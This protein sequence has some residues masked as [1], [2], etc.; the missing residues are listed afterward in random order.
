MDLDM[1]RR[2]QKKVNI[3]LVIGKADCLTKTEVQKLKKRILSDLED[4]HIHLYQFPDCDS[5]EDE[6]FKQQD[7]ELKAC[8]PFAVV[9]SNVILEVAGKK[10]RGRQYPWGVVDVEN[11]EHS[12]FIKL[13]TMLISTHM[14]D[15]K[16]TTQDVHYENFRAQCI[17]QISQHAL[18]ER[19][20]LKRDSVSSNGLDQNETDRLLLQKD[21]E[22]RRMQDMLTQMQEKLKATHFK[23]MKMNN[24]HSNNNS[25]SVID[26]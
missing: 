21:E 7:R 22:I 23:E 2:L 12:D 9:G 25:D 18:R 4:N 26:V 24:N 15:L 11:P 3:V 13:R 8:L 16:D 20:K 19:N 10:V 6:E 1:L 14:Q 17:S 5:D